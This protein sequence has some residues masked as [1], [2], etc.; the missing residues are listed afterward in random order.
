VSATANRA[1]HG[2]HAAQ[3]ATDVV[4]P[5][6]AACLADTWPAAH[7]QHWS[8]TM[9]VQNIDVRRKKVATR[10]ARIEGQVRGVKSLVEQGADCEAIGVQMT[11]AR[12]A[13]DRAFYEMLACSLLNEV[14]DATSAQKIRGPRTS[15]PGCS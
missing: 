3:H 14:E 5:Y 10:L 9:P 11:A 8:T 7:Y 4:P 13:L 1:S 15:S 12:R 6:K 2:V